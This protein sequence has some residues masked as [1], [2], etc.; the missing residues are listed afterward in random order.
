MNNVIYVSAILITTVTFLV[1]IILR[2]KNYMWYTKAIRD[3]I[4]ISN[5]KNCH[6]KKISLKYTNMQK[7]GA[8]YEE[9]YIYAKRNVDK[10][11]FLNRQ[12][13]ILRCI[14]IL[15]IYE[16][17]ITSVISGK[18]LLAPD[19]SID[20]SNYLLLILPLTYLCITL[21]STVILDS[22]Y[23]KEMLIYSVSEALSMSKTG[24]EADIPVQKPDT[25]KDMSVSVNLTE[26]E[27]KIVEEVMQEFLS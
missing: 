11:S 9:P 10:L 27:A 12:E 1:G 25:K 18:T 26:E 8:L 17:V 21:I 13:Q 22:S 3:S 19:V 16:V 6:L 23:Q 14:Q 4:H 5:T 2:I 7:L 24:R 20:I 15:M